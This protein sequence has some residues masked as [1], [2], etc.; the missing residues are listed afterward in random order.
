MNT[1]V[2]LLTYNSEDYLDDCISSILKN[3]NNDDQL[4]IIDNN[5]TDNTKK[6]LKKY[7]N[8]ADVFL[9]DKNLGVSGGRNLAA[10]LAKN[11]LLA[12]IDSDIIL[13][14]GSLR[15]AK[16]TFAKC[17]ADAVIGLFEDVGSGYNWFIE[18]RR[19]IYSPKRKQAVKKNISLKN[20]ACFC[21]GLCLIDKQIFNKYHGYDISYNNY[22]S[23]DVNLELL[24]L[25]DH[26]TII[27]EKKFC[28]KH[29]K[30]NM[31]LNGLFKKFYKNGVAVVKLIK[32]SIQNKYK[33][34]FNNS[35]PYLPI[36][37]ILEIFL[38][39]LSFFV[40]WLIIPFIFFCLVRVLPVFIRSKRGVIY[41]VRF[42]II[43]FF[44]D[45]FMF[46]SM[47]YVLVFK[48]DCKNV[49]I[50]YSLKKLSEGD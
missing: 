25:R 26:L 43:R 24:M 16:E 42:I 4:L 3:I 13:N 49:Q 40:N 33:I 46:F 6:I 8:V 44:L 48:M 5:S 18:M 21:G 39:V 47:L 20:F 11:D 36:I 34:P 22:P 23:E 41:N 12:F 7:K 14:D 2:I 19:E 28:G 17:N 15:V 1:S 50:K 35:W 27:F 10:K 32:S 37:P 29:Y 31:S 38:L 45:I 9:C 30:K